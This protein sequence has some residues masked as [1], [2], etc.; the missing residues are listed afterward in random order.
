MP[1]SFTHSGWGGD[2]V[3]GGGGGSIQA[4]L[5][6]DVFDHG[7]TVMTSMLGMNDGR[8]R[9]FDPALFEEFAKGYAT[10]VDLVRAKAPDCRITL[11]RPSTYDDF[12]RPPLFEG[13]YNAVL[14]RY[15]DYLAKL[16]NERHCQ[17][18]DLNAL[19]ASTLRSANA[20][21]PDLA[22]RLLPDRVHPG[23]GGHLVMAQA[24]LDAW[25]APSLVSNTVLDANPRNVIATENTNVT[26]FA[27][28]ESLSWNQL[29]GALPMPLDTRDASLALAA[30]H[31]GFVARLNRQMLTI[32][33]VPAGQWQLSIDQQPVAK[34]SDAAL[35]QGVNLATF[36]TPMGRQARRV[37]D[38]T[39]KRTRIRN[40]RWREIQVPLEAE[41]LD[42]RLATLSEMDGIARELERAQRLA[43]QPLEHVFKL[44]RTS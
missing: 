31:S 21:N 11:I 40:L 30:K 32:H 38:L 1:I 37:H 8:Y 41:N 10:I 36:E 13:G 4:R 35:R 22:Q 28:E 20:E 14:V 42:G 12:T 43:A 39:L 7:A 18:A 16:A 3:T 27:V 5:Q 6:R 25:R 29:D 2:R 19:L 23:P 9:A 17:I 26:D 33:N 44:E 15:G 34:F 24:L